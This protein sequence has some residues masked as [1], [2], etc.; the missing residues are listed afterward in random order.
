MLAKK[1]YEEHGNLLIPLNYSVRIGNTT[2]YLGK[3]LYIQK[4]NY[5]RN[6][7]LNEVQIG[8]LNDIKIDWN[9]NQKED[10]LLVKY[11]YVD[12]ENLKE[13][14]KIYVKRNE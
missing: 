8:L 10:D 1:Y 4:F 5:M 3:W 13:N 6:M 9:I 2:I 14:E 7:R 11:N 12:D